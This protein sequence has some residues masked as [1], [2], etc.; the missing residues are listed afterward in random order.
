MFKKFLSLFLSMCIISSFVN[1]NLFVLPVCAEETEQ[2]LTANEIPD[3]RLREV[4]QNALGD[5]PLTPT[6][7]AE[8]TKLS[9]WSKGIT[10]LKGLEYCAG[11]Q[12][13]DLNTNSISDISPLKELTSLQWLSLRDN[14]ISDISS[15]EELTS[16][17]TLLLY[18][19]QIS[20]IS[21]LS[22]LADLIVYSYGQKPILETFIFGSVDSLELDVSGIKDRDNSVLSIDNIQHFDIND[23]KK[24]TNPTYD[25]ENRKIQLSNVDVG[26][27]VT[28]AFSS[29]IEQ[30]KG[31]VTHILRQGS[32]SSVPP[33]N[34]GNPSIPHYVVGDKTYVKI[35]PNEITWLKEKIDDSAHWFG[36]KLP[37]DNTQTV[38]MSNNYFYVEWISPEKVLQH[39]EYANLDPAEKDKIQDSRGK[40]FYAG[41]ADEHGNKIDVEF[42]DEDP[43]KLYVKVGSDWETHDLQSVFIKTETDEKISISYDGTVTDPDQE[44]GYAVM[45]LTHFSPYFVYDAE[46]SGVGDSPIQ[47]PS[48]SGDSSSENDSEEKLDE[49]KEDKNEELENDYDNL[50][51]VLN[52]FFITGDSKTKIIAWSTVGLILTALGVLVFIKKYRKIK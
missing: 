22:R 18:N 30:F 11:L 15:L 41:I 12:S 31:T 43:A 50:E 1:I 20:D 44:T 29:P 33:E 45:N 14:Q 25:A 47:A 8:L 46:T 13:L 4:L 27:Y 3:A 35:N 23:N 24:Q 28:Y 36:L 40:L 9:A 49:D 51:S 38:D 42:S 19:N 21:P 2:E 10:N 52:D 48:G 39:P 26:D 34:Y 17:Q 32:L 5:K 7:L 37:D 6:N 16:L